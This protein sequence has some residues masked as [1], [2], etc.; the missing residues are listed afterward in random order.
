M[1][2]GDLYKH[3]KCGLYEFIGISIPLKDSLI[4]INATNLKKTKIA[5]FEENLEDTYL[6]EIKGISNQPSN[7]GLI[8]TDTDIPYVVYK[9]KDTNI[10]WLRRADD[11]FGFTKNQYNVLVKRFTRT[12]HF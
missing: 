2:K 10:I 12:S 3:Y 1:N 6:Y 5:K 7:S 4:N 9:S 11:F 8:V